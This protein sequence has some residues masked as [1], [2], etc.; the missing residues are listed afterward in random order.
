M[1]MSQFSYDPILMAAAGDRPQSVDDVLQIM[2]TIDAT[3][4]DGDGL[5]WFN[6]LYLQVTEAVKAGIAEGGTHDP[7]W[8]AALDVEFASLYFGAL[9]AT[10]RG[11]SCP[12]C[13][14]SLF[15][16]RSDTQL[17]R[18]QFALSG[19]NAHINHDLPEAIV[20]TCQATGIV[21]AHGSPQYRDYS[22]LN[23]TLDRL[24]DTAKTTLRV[25]LLGDALPL[26]SHLENTVAA[27][28][29]AAARE[30]SWTNAEVLSHLQGAPSL[31]A[32]FIESLD[33]ITTVVSKT[34]LAPVP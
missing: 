20:A 24:V 1:A 28:S 5:K 11:A 32:G 14:R 6:W 33:G 13:W 15:D 26:A 2:H 17:A 23:A 29:M 21:P 9:E 19:I 34:L 7:Q 27:W 16:V 30:N 25:R 12:R 4:T 22:A 10:L 31:A 3:C 18:I 8:L